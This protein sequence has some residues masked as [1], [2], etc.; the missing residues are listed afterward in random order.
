MVNSK[1]T[2]Q[3]IK[4]CNHMHS[5]IN[6]QGPFPC[7]GLVPKV[8]DGMAVGPAPHVHLVQS[9]ADH[10]LAVDHSTSGPGVAGTCSEKHEGAKRAHPD[11]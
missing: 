2:W 1:F 11:N 7:K 6:F 9:W 5:L 4:E 10:F 3:P 8:F